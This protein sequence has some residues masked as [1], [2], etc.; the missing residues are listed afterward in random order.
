MYDTKSPS[1]ITARRGAYAQRGLCR[2]KMSV[3]P[4]VRPSATRRYS[5]NTSEHIL[6]IFSPLCSSTILVFRTEHYGN[7][8]TGTPL[9]GASNE[10][11]YEKIAIFDQYIALSPK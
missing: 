7:I 8:L 9:T 11:R 1:V 2:R 5:V 6:K 10:I 4:V 3:R